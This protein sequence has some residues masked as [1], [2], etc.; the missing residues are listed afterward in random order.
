MTDRSALDRARTSALDRIDRAERRYRIAFLGAV[1]FEAAFL[2]AYLL[3]ADLH[4]RTHL[5][6]LLGSVGAYGI[7]VLGLFALGAHVSRCA[8]RV[9]R[10]IEA[11]DA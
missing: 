4:Q 6:I 2:G 9:L 1:L 7:V 8:D 10:A 3:L 11:D 5:L